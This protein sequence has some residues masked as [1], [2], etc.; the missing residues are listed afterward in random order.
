MGIK[1]GPKR[2]AKST[3]KPLFKRYTRKIDNHA[4][5]REYAKNRYKEIAE[6]KDS[7]E[8]DYRGYDKEVLRVLTQD[9]GHNR[10]DVVIY[11]YLK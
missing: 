7:E 11:N 2:T 10:L 1:P 9:L 8:K 6:E 5:R 4:L 3:G